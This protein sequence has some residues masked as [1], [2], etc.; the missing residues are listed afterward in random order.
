MIERIQL[1]E[2]MER[3][4]DVFQRRQ[5]DHVATDMDEVIHHNGVC[6]KVEWNAETGPNAHYKVKNPNN[7]VMDVHGNKFTLEMRIDGFQD[8]KMMLEHKVGIIVLAIIGPCQGTEAMIVKRI[9]SWSATG[10]TWKENP[11]HA[12]DLITWAGLEQSRAAAMTPSTAA[13]TKTLRN[14]SAE[15]SCERGKAGSVDGVPEDTAYSIHK[16]NRI[17]YEALIQKVIFE[18]VDVNTINTV[19]NSTDTKLLSSE[20][21]ESIWTSSDPELRTTSAR[22]VDTDWMDQDSDDQKCFCCVSRRLGNCVNDVGWAKRA[23]FTPISGQR[24]Y[25]DM[26]DEDGNDDRGGLGWRTVA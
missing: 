18:T 23:Q 16:A 24:P 13:T 2:I 6:M 1:V 9:L 3:G 7:D 8:A 21:P 11:Q 20:E 14:T 10:F 26:Y 22:K 25:Q 19:M 15:F 12:L 5:I 17:G 4:E